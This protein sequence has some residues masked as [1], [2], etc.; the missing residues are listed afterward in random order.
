MLKARNMIAV[1]G[2]SIS[3]NASNDKCYRHDRK[4]ISSAALAAL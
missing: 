3:A 4:N 2:S 1:G